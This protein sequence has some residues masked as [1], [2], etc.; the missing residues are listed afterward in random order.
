GFLFFKH[1]FPNLPNYYLWAIRL[2]IIIFV[3]FSFEG[4]AMGSRL[5]HSVGAL[6]DNS[7]W[8]IVGWSKTVGD[9]R[10]S[11]FIGMH[12][13]QFLPFFSFYVLKNTKL[14]FALSFVYGLLALLTLIQAI[15]GKP[16]IRQ[17]NEVNKIR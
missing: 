1:D 5:N 7:N 17:K 6:N 4:F 12:A 13:L 11:H 3:L 16:L 10:V 8:F 14:T 2:S 9:L 15:Q